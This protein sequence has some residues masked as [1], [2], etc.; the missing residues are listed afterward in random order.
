MCSVAQ[1]YGLIFLPQIKE[2]GAFL[3]ITE[4]FHGCLFVLLLY[5]L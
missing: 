1:G 5:L 4:I 2:R 3:W